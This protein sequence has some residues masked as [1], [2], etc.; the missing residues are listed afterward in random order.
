M[1]I[2]DHDDYWPVLVADIRATRGAVKMQVPY[3]TQKGLD[4]WMPI[5]TE[6][7]NKGKTVCLV[8]QRPP[9]WNKLERGL[10]S[11]DD[12]RRMRHFKLM[13]DSLLDSGVH[14]ELREKIHAKFI[15]KDEDVLWEGSLNFL[16]HFDTTEHV[17]RSINRTEV[18]E[19][20]KRHKLNDCENCKKVRSGHD[21]RLMELI[22][23][24][25]E[26]MGLSQGDLAK[27]I[28]AVQSQVC[29]LESGETAPIHKLFLQVLCALRLRLV[30]VPDYLC[31][32]VEKYVTDA[33]EE[34]RK[35]KAQRARQTVAKKGM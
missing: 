17:R 16:S 1:A 2:Y 7:I 19:V 34:K 5:F 15:I 20:S 32:P 35:L 23:K 31:G 13:I 12:L 28:D 29:R 25:R 24:R 3:I 4:R 21:S 10:L 22:T 8:L 14:V 27:A 11:G 33:I 26:V 9:E 18:N 30:L 6:C